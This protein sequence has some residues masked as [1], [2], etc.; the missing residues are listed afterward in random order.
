M[1]EINKIWLEQQKDAMR[2]ACWQISQEIGT[3]QQALQ[4]RQTK[5]GSLIGSLRTYEW[6]LTQI[7]PEVPEVTDGQ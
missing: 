4:E 5:L 2:S 3:L 1:I 7:K 6:M